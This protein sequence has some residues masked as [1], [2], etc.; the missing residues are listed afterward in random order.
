MTRKF[1]I[2]LEFLDEYHSRESGI[3]RAKL[4]KICGDSV[5]KYDKKHS[6]NRR[7]SIDHWTVKGDGSCGHEVTSPVLSLDYSTIVNLRKI[8]SD[9]K[10]SFKKMISEPRSISSEPID[11]QCGYHVHFDISDIDDVEKFRNI[12]YGFYNLDQTLFS[13]FP[14]TRRNGYYSWPLKRAYYTACGTSQNWTP[15]LI[16]GIEENSKLKEHG[17]CFNVYRYRKGSRETC[18]I[19]H[20]SGTCD[21]ND[22][23]YWILIC[24]LIIECGKNGVAFRADTV[25]ELKRIVVEYGKHSIFKRYNKGMIKWINQRVKLYG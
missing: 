1:G 4:V 7:E 22:V 24:A 14:Q 6:V 3:K 9:I 25:N 20:A 8:I 2:E 10:K 11:H 13:L 23:I 21:P 18:E 16:Q 5:S 19:R 12:A 17:S 15:D